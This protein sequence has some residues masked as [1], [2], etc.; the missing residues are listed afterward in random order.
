MQCRRQPKRRGCHEN[1]LAYCCCTL[2]SPYRGPGFTAAPAHAKSGIEIVDATAVI[3]QADARWR[4]GYRDCPGGTCQG[5][6]LQP[7]VDPWN[8]RPG[9]ARPGPEHATRGRQ[10]FHRGTRTAVG[11]IATGLTAGLVRGTNHQ[12]TRPLA[13]ILQYQR[14]LHQAAPVISGSAPAGVALPYPQHG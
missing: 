3:Q 10:R 1:S 14:L 11:P 13:G 12:A 9:C 8:P 2:L 5:R 6:G 7:P 4:P